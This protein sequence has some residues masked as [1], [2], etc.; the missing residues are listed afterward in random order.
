MV[1]MARCFVVVGFAETRTGSQSGNCSDT[2]HE[3]KMTRDL[4]ARNARDPRTT[5]YDHG[6]RS[7]E[8][9]YISSH[10]TPLS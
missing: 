4:V 10:S 6:D 8:V 1:E 2:K 3:A 5:K 9:G 7:S